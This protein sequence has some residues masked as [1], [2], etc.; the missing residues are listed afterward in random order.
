VLWLC[1]AVE[2]GRV[3][4]GS[5]IARRSVLT[6]RYTHKIA[7]HAAKKNK[8]TKGRIRCRNNPTFVIGNMLWRAVYVGLRTLLCLF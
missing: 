1:R 5:G 7:E 2:G 8:G 6:P 4:G 3:G